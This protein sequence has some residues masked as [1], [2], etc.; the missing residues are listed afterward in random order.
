[1]RFNH[2]RYSKLDTMMKKSRLK[3]LSK[4]KVRRDTV[5]ADCQYGKSH[6]LPYEESNSRAKEPLELIHYDAFGPIKQASIGGMKVQEILEGEIGKGV[7]CLR[8]DNIGEYTLDEFSDF[9]REAKIH[10]QFTCP[11]TPQ[12]NGVFERKNRHL[13]EI[14]R[15]M[16]HAKN[17]PKQF[18]VEAMKTTTF[19]INRLP[20]Q[21]KMEKKA[22][23]CVFVGYDSQRKGWRCYDPTTEKCYTSRNVVFDEEFS[24]WSSSKEVL[25]KSNVF[26]EALEDSQIKLISEIEAANSDQDVNEG[27]SQNP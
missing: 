5:C 6:Q 11:N 1:M 2:V 21:S 15:S 27:T 24:W 18:W 26:E 23:R 22:I 4:L 13:A 25:P 7:R 14:C 9:T 17:V 12:Q 8:T 3:G 19:V 20:Q 16:I 10:Q